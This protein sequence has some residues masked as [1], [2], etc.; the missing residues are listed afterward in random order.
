MLSDGIESCKKE[1]MKWTKGFPLPRTI[2]RERTRRFCGGSQRRIWS[3]RLQ[4]DTLFTDM[5]YERGGKH[6]IAMADRIR[7]ALTEKGYHLVAVSPTNQIF[8]ELNEAQL[9]R[10]SEHVVMGFGEKHGE[11]ETVMHIATSWT[12]QE[13][14]AARLIAVL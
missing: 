8:L 9:A 11:D 5:L 6:A 10:L 1:T 14:D 7:T 12:T 2:W 3:K 13:A 4:F